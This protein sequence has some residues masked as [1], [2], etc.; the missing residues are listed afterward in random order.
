MWLSLG[1]CLTQAGAQLP[2]GVAAV[3]NVCQAAGAKDVSIALFH[4]LPSF[5]VWD[6]GLDVC[7]NRNTPIPSQCAAMVKA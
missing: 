1:T 3:I 2:R 6:I 4:A 5:S 7:A